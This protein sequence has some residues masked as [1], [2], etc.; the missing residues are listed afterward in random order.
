MDTIQIAINLN[1]DKIGD[2]S[3]KE[4]QKIAFY[5]NG[6]TSRY[7][8]RYCDFLSVS[9]AGNIVVKLSYPRFYGGIN[10]CIISSSK[11]CMKVQRDFC[12]ELN[13]NKLLE[14]A[15]IKLNRVDIPF[16]FFMDESYY[17]SSFKKVYQIFN[18]VYRKKNSKVDPKAYVDIAKFRPETLI[19]ADTKNISGY[20]SKITIYNQYNNIKIKT[21]DDNEFKK[22]LFQYPDLKNRMRIEVSKRIQRKGFTIEEFESFDIFREY[23][24]NYKKYLLDNIFDLEEIDKIYDELAYE[25]AEK[26]NRCRTFSKNFNY[27]NFIY[28]EIDSIYDYEIIR[29]ALKRVIGNIKTRENAITSIRKILREYQTDS[30]IIVMNTYE[31]IEEIREVIE[32]C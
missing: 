9:N 21:F 7:G 20:N 31:A 8:Y 22:I 30:G 1:K 2:T 14:D 4:V 11:E 19:Y 18:F 5:I 28:K 10:A 27:E 16:T 15:E 29:R 32:T 17:F 25:L 26:L 23:S 3:Y 24:G 13:K 12:N 6:I